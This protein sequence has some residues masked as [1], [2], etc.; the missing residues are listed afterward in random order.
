MVL[1]Y[2]GASA[3]ISALEL[4][5]Y[6]SLARDVSVVVVDLS[7]AYLD[8]AAGALG[9]ERVVE[10]IEQRGADAVLAGVSSASAPGIAALARRHLTLH[11]ELPLAIATAFQIA[12]AQRRVY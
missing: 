10:A 5:E 8:A 9:L 6:D 4:I 12:D 2:S 1:P 7:G 11:H 3:S